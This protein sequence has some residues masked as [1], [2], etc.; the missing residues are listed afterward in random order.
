MNREKIAERILAALLALSLLQ[1]VFP[2]WAE[3]EPLPEETA[4]QTEAIQPQTT[5]PPT[6]P[7]ITGAPEEPEAVE[8]TQ[9]AT[10]PEVPEPPAT[11]GEP[12][13]PGL[14]EETVIPLETEIPEETE[15]PEE[16]PVPRLLTV[17]QVLALE[18]GTEQVTTA[19][20]VV[21]LMGT[22]AI[23]QDDTGGLRMA[24]EEAPEIAPGD[25][26]VVTGR[27]S[28]GFLVESFEKTGSGD[29][30][31]VE[32]NLEEDR[33]NLRIVVRNA[34]LGQRSLTQKGCSY[35][36]EGSLPADL[37]TGAAVDA[38]GVLIDG[39][40]YAD[41]IAPAAAGPAG[42]TPAHNLGEWNFYFGQLHAHSDISD[43]AGTP[44][45]AFAHAYAAEN[46]DFFALTDHSNSFDHG[47]EGSVSTD[48]A[49]LSTE[50]AAGKAAAAAVTD[51]TFVGIFGYE[52]T[53]Q[54]EL[55]IGHINT[56][57]T[58][59]WQTREQQGMGTLE[60][61]LD[62]LEQVPGAVS[63]FN[64]PGQAYGE[65]YDFSCYHPRYDRRMHLL[66]VGGEE[67]FTA[68]GYYTK[69]LDKGWHLAPSNNQN[70]HHGNW[71]TENAHRTVVLAKELTE[72]SIY[73]AIRNYRVYATEDAD[74]K[75]LY[76]LNGALMGS[77][78]PEATPLT[79]RIV[80]ADDTDGGVGLV[81]VI[82]E[83]G[84]VAASATAEGS[85]L[86]LDVPGAA[87]YYYLRITQ[88][89]GDI[90]VTAPVWVE[91]YEDLGVADFAA[92]NPKPDVGTEAT[93]TLTLYNEESAA[94][95]VES[96]AF[97]AGEQLLVT[98][99]EPGTVAPAETLDIPVTC[100]RQ[101][102]GIMTICAKVI[103]T[104]AGITRT[105]DASVTMHW[106][107][108]EAQPLSIAEARELT[109]GETCRVRGYVT[110][111]TSKTCNSFPRS[112]YLQ[113]ETGGIQIADFT[114]R[115]IQVGTP[116]EAE[117][118]LLHRGGNIL[119]ALTDYAIPRE[120]YHR[121][122]PG[123]MSNRTATDY[124]TNGGELLQIEGS[125]VS[126]TKTADGDG[127]SRFTIRDIHGDLATVMVEAGIGSGAYGVNELASEVKTKRTVRAMG[128]VHRD[129]FGQTVLRV[130]NCDEVAYVPP[131]KDPTNPKT[132]D[133]LAWLFSRK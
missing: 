49:A 87:G 63:Q 53:W 54:E 68:Y 29:M 72:A 7:E 27:R 18:A 108:L 45:E 16:P 76:T 123:I 71:G 92:D 15:Q 1:P 3:E 83:E 37:G 50:W 4:G 36:L 11:E 119:L 90:A 46:L 12:E 60:G 17:A 80:V 34:V 42:E 75:V 6:E 95:A 85:E 2:A 24:F 131:R 101:E 59:G 98:V 81:E 91:S 132:G 62:A 32:S 23:L 118:V 116:M 88:P 77:V 48:G 26:L 10:P 130:R 107:P 82:T 113:D 20:T 103:G 67:G 41:T 5:E 133:W 28:G 39:V 96:V 61:Y 122:A 35:S 30:P 105:C 84:A 126:V 22:Q 124:E 8:T 38:W 70:N 125:V 114:E 115:G 31:A 51:D 100:T 106:Q 112:I 86:L 73:D 120:A 13:E 9:P 78:I 55:A 40:F 110:A 121:Y 64:H 47:S 69:A 14:P 104:I 44:D 117:G 58:A 65:F 97:F 66:E 19:G 56:F 94:F 25:I 74:L 89:D 79:A 57:G 127:V 111:G 99:L 129:E 109:P 21:F 52:M 128:L 33:S 102:P 43:G 93:M